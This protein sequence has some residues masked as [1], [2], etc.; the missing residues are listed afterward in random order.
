MYVRYDS[1]QGHS[2]RPRYVCVDQAD[3]RRASCQSLPATDVDAATVRLLLDLLTPDAVEM[4]LAVQSE[5][6]RLTAQGE[7]HHQL[8]ITRAR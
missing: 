3:A 1:R 7:H 5:L 6:D 8:R 4:T 2:V